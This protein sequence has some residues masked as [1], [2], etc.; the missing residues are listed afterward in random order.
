MSDCK[1]IKNQDERRS[2]AL[3]LHAAHWGSSTSNSTVSADEALQLLDAK[4][5]RLLA[6][7][8]SMH[9]DRFMASPFGAAFF[10]MVRSDAVQLPKM[11]I[12]SPLAPPSLTWCGGTRYLPKMVTA[13]RS[14]AA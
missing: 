2:D 9:L 7:L 12:A 3:A 11:V 10:D 14:A 8:Q 13:S 4:A 6:Q 1:S 5:E